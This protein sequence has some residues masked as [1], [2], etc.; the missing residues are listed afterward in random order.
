M[1][2]NSRPPSLRRHKG[3]GQ[4]VVTLNHR[5]HYL[6]TWPNDQRK[7]PAG[8]QQAY[9]TL[10]AE[11]LACGRQLPAVNGQRLTIIEVIARHWEHVLEHYRRPDGTI[12]SEAHE[13]AISLRPLNY[14]YGDLP[15]A[16]FSPLK[17]QA[18]RR[19]MVDGYSHPEFG[20]QQALARKVVNQ[21]IGRTV[22]MFKWATSQELVPPDVYHGLKS[23]TGL[24][25]GRTKA[26]EM[27]PIRP[28]HDAAVDAIL[29]Y[30]SPEL[31]AM[32]RVQGNTG[33][34]PGEVTIMRSCDID[35]TGP[36][37]IYRPA[38]H[39]LAYRG[40]PRTVALGPRAQE[41]IRPFL[42][43]QTEA[44]LFSPRAARERRYT[45]MRAKRKTPVQ[46]SQL[47]RRKKK[48]RKLPGDHYTSGTYS[49]AVRDACDSAFPPPEPLGRR[50][51]ESKRAWWR[52]LTP[53]QRTEVLAWQRQHRWFPNQ[54]R[55]SFATKARKN[56]GLEGAQVILGHA[57][58]T[59]S[60]IYAERDMALAAKVALAIG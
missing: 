9:D 20:P 41:V 49:Q 7:A 47:D 45:E 40:K 18:V 4:G 60:E 1:G 10:I 2:S 57:H 5:D 30:L 8:V 48:P 6:G 3:S 22:R 43:L 37:W 11:W 14:L 35:M 26:K 44:F 50:E 36:V 29:P 27:Q 12:T 24:Q 58:A 16:D 39:K 32:V 31:A 19:L 25:L 34:R 59:T 17:L 42:T 51:G 15:A 38:Y 53:E 55:H 54:L 33:M 13:Y 23:V 28:V 56:H 46:P 21:R 52:R